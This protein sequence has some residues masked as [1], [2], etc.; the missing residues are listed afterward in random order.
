MVIVE[1]LI[2]DLPADLAGQ[3]DYAKGESLYILYAHME[4]PPQVALGE[5]VEA[6][7]VLGSVGKSGNAGITHLHLETR[8]GP[9]GQQFASMAFY[10]VQ[11]SEEEKANYLR[12]RISWDFRHFNPMELLSFMQGDK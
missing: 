7:Q 6:C 1:T 12:W 3:L 8:L 10:D 9:A 4:Q 2:E 11:A 5:V